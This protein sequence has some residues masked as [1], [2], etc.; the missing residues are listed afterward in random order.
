MNSR[1]A[2]V[3]LAEVAGGHQAPDRLLG[4]A[5]G[6]PRELRGVAHEDPSAGAGRH[7]RD[8]P[9]RATG[10][11]LPGRPADAAGGYGRGPG[12]W[13]WRRRP[14]RWNRRGCTGSG[15]KASVACRHRSAPSCEP[16]TSTMRSADRS[17]PPAQP[18]PGRGCR[19]SIT[20]HDD[21]RAD[22]MRGPG[23]PG[24]QRRRNGD[25]GSAC[26]PGPRPARHARRPARGTSAP[27]IR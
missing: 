2:S 21:Q 14:P 1:P 27:G 22:P 6:V 3:E 10:P 8:P 12:A 9:R 11:P 19:R 23:F 24:W 15:P 4:P 18:G 16:P 5:A 20:G 13:Q 7:R 25:A 26:S 17:S